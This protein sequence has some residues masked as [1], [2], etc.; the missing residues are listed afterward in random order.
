MDFHDL[1]SL[2]ESH[3]GWRLLAADHAPLVTAFLNRA[4]IE[5]NQRVLAESELAEQLEDYLHHLREIEGEDAFPKAARAYLVDWSADTR[6]WLRRFYTEDSD[7]PH[8]DLTPPTEKAIGWL[9]GLEQPHFV[10]AESRLLT[11]F[12]LLR[13]IV[14]GS[15][16]DPEARIAELEAKKDE[17]EREIDNIRAGRLGLLDDT[18]LRERFLQMAE[19]ARALLADFRQ[20]EDN[21]R[22]LDR[23]VR[24]RITRFEGSKG[25]VL[26]D[27]FGEQDAI[28]ESDQGRSFRAFWDFLMSPAR[29]DEFAQMLERVLALEPIVALRPDRRLRRIHDDWLG[30]GEQT[31]RTIA[32]LSEQL[33]RFLDDQ[34]W[35]ENRRIMDLI[36]HI[37]QQALEVREQPPRDLAIGLDATAPTI[38]LPLE[39]PLY[40]PPLKPHIDTQT[41]TEGEA[42]FDSDAL[43]NQLYV[44]RDQLRGHIRRA[45]QTR[46]QVDLQTL[47]DEHPLALGL[48]ELVSYLAIAAEDEHA[49]IDESQTREITWTGSDGVERRARVPGVIFSR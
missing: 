3:A 23:Q 41:L 39:R 28:A 13:Q 32:R 16:T 25:E 14:T 48:A 37:E 38:E 9:R 2:R 26:A 15:E 30:A 20:V 24:E 29:Q 22:T 12:E 19:T 1:K 44:D 10:G 42:T 17:L 47:I 8:Y 49:L 4:F 21:F 46:T 33:R 31:Q 43:F 34:A 36:Q 6:G 45:L 5:P 11:V 18:R 40:A 27:I 35:L 7:E